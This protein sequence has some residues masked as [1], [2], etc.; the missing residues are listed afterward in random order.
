MGDQ[1][2]GEVRPVA[3]QSKAHEDLLNIIDSLRSQGISRYIDLPQLIVCGDQ[4]SGKSSVL[5]AVSGIRFPTKDNLC[6]RFATELILRR[7]PSTSASVTIVP[8]ADRSESEKAKLQRFQHEISDLDQFESLVDSAKSVMGLDGDAR[9]FSND[10]LRV[11]ISGPNQPHLTLVDLPGLFSAGNKTQSDADAQVVKSLVLSYMKKSRSIILAV[12]SAKNDFANQIVTKY[13]RDIDPQGL[14]TLG[15][16]TKP[17]TLPPGSDSEKSFVELAENK[18]V[19]FRLGWHVLRNRDYETRDYTTEE[20]DQMERDFFSK[21]IWTSLPSNHILTEL[22]SL[23]E[24]VTRGIKD[25]KDIITRLG[26]SRATLSDQRLHLV[27]LS[28]E[29]SR[30]A[31]SATDGFYVDEFFGSAMQD[32]GKSKRLRAVIQNTCSDFSEAI[33]RKGHAKQIVDDS[34][35][36]GTQTMGP[37]KTHRSDFIDEVMTLMR[38]SRGR[39]LPGTY[40]PLLIGDLFYEQ[41]KPWTE[42]VEQYTGTILN[43]TRTAL[44]AILDHTSDETT[45]QGLLRYIINPKM[46]ALQH[47]LE[48]KVDSILEPHK[49]GHPIT[50]NHYFTDNIQK[51]KAQHRKDSLIEQLGSFFGVDF[52][53]G[54]IKVKEHSFDVKSLLDHLAQGPETDM[55]RYACSE[56]IDCMQ[57]YY[58]VAMKTI[59]DD[60]SVLAIEKCLV[61]R[62]PDLLSPETIVGL[63]DATISSI[64]AETEESR[65]ERSRATE[66]LKV[67]ESTLVVLRSLDRHQPTRTRRQAVNTILTSKL[68]E[69]NEESDSS[70]D[71]DSWL[72]YSSSEEDDCLGGRKQKLPPKRGDGSSGSFGTPKFGKP[73]ASEKSAEATPVPGIFFGMAKPEKTIASERP[74]VS[75]TEKSAATE[76]PTDAAPAF[77]ISTYTRPPNSDTTWG[78]PVFGNPPSSANPTFSFGNSQPSSSSGKVTQNEKKTTS[79]FGQKLASSKV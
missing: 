67:L 35:E 51:A 20:R 41:S 23:I 64:A 25:C 60:F 9:A 17:D 55:D 53:R 48:A 68:P 19:H 6:T 31:K 40:N 1:K 21:G 54:K 76:K 47:D 37:F 50:Y 77:T 49:R 33:R 11:E 3:L 52:E 44:N 13:A 73:I 79:L 4:S 62:L 59:V 71:E 5:E 56:A 70:A 27:R 29:F 30:L 15:I 46:D 72:P 63:D 45:G 16:I 2:L 28:Q 8:N 26:E 10:I 65:L 14:R 61:K 42:L 74:A 36:V 12:V 58:K 32:V 24:D 57:A 75:R 7:G 34:M 18:D 69:D 38:R 22:P 39:E 43:A 66:K 78:A